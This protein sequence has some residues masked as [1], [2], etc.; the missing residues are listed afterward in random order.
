MSRF[1]I[2]ITDYDI[3]SW[4]CYSDNFVMR[5]GKLMFNLRTFISWNRRQYE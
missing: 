5:K 4:Y 1:K 3:G 2:T